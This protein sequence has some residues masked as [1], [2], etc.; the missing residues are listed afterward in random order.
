MPDRTEKIDG[1]VIQVRSF[2]DQVPL[3]DL[4]SKR[5]RIPKGEASVLTGVDVVAR[6]KFQTERFKS[7][8]RVS[9]PVADRPITSV[10]SLEA[11]SSVLKEIKG[12]FGVP[13]PIADP[14]TYR[15]D[16]FVF[17]IDLDADE[18]KATY[19]PATGVVNKVGIFANYVFNENDRLMVSSKQFQGVHKIRSRTDDDNIV[20]PEGLTDSSGEFVGVLVQ[21]RSLFIKNRVPDVQQEEWLIKS[22]DLYDKEGSWDSDI[23]GSFLDFNPDEREEI[24]KRFTV[25]RLGTFANEND[26]LVAED[27][28]STGGFALASKVTHKFRVRYLKPAKS[29]RQ[30]ILVSNGRK[31]WILSKGSYELVMDLGDNIYLGSV[32]RG[33][34]ISSSRFMLTTDKFPPRIFP[35]DSEGVLDGDDTT[36]SGLLRPGKPPSIET[37]VNS[38]SRF[39]ITLQV[40]RSGTPLG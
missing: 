34:R 21:G 22:P 3:L 4:S 19:D 38:F 29:L 39:L 7:P 2:A 33:A 36:L 1:V 27:T 32:W 16:P 26:S 18:T 14:R 6:G 20:I 31:F 10:I 37:I 8:V 30:G 5:S 15:G 28:L 9:I 11:E 17:L 24:I 25:V 13:D 40:S 23:V 35:I 12:V